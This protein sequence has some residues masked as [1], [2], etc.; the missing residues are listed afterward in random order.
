MT[1]RFKC[2]RVG[3][4]ERWREREVERGMER[5]RGGERDGEALSSIRST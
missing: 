1:V 5:E 2:Q 4:K 3:E